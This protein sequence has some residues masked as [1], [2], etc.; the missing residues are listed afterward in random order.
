MLWLI[1]DVPFPLFNS[2]LRA[3]L[4]NPNSEI[5]AAVARGRQRNVPLMWWI[6]P[7]TEPANLGEALTA[8][9]FVHEE[10]AGMAVDLHTLPQNTAAPAGLEIKL[11]EDTKTL[12][13][14]CRALCIGY[15]FPDFVGEAYFD[16]A[17]SIGLDSQP[18]FRN[19]V[20]LLN[21]EPVATSSMF[22]GAGVGG[23]YNV[24]TIPEAR[25]RGIG[26]NMT[27]MPLLKARRLGYKAGILQAS[28]M[29]LNIYR[30]LG[31]REYCK[32]MSYVW[33]NQ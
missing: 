10:V 26:A 5:E 25:R 29:G 2:I 19:Y 33:L 3:H 13:K 11:V 15:E 31:F 1:T 21:G 8:F 22:L 20:G 28:S 12:E 6:G 9:G 17:K 14:Y 27:L 18:V 23:I 7:S 32:V 4:S 16:L 30:K 24:A